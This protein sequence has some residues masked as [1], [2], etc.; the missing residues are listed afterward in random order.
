MRLLVSVRDVDEAL[1]AAAAGA[2]FIDLKDPSSGALGGLPPAAIA[3]I[4]DALR[5]LRPR[6]GISATVGDAD[7]LDAAQVLD[8][9]AGVARCGVDYVKVGIARGAQGATLLRALA[10]CHAA[11]VPVLLADDG[12]DTDLVRQALAMPGF[13]ALMLDTARKHDGSLLQRLPADVL[14]AFVRA[15][16]AASRLAGLAGT[17]RIEDMPALRSL[18]PD[19]AGF[20]TAV[21]AAG[22]AG[23]LDPARVRHLCALLR[24]ETAV[25]GA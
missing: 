7:D 5:P 13:P 6:A 12:V 1:A 21:C 19:F 24:H 14:V 22:R 17:L 18:D 16:R 15:V 20:R 11:V 3:R 2:D 10:G 9:V 8:R 25:I 4:V 23:A